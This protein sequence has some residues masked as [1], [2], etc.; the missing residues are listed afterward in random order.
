MALETQVQ[1]LLSTK[2]M[3]LAQ[4]E[5]QGTR[6]EDKHLQPCQEVPWKGVKPTWYKCRIPQNIVART[7][8]RVVDCPGML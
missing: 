5:I 1:G 7:P 4:E 2:V 6:G 8:W 3:P